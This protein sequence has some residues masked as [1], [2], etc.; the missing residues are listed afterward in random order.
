M[1]FVNSIV[2]CA[3]CE[4]KKTNVLIFSVTSSYDTSH[5]SSKSVVK[6]LCCYKKRP[7][8]ADLAFYTGLDLLILRFPKLM[9]LVQLRFIRHA[10]RINVVSRM[11]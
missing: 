3:C 8:Y 7:H 5:A 10:Q 1:S 11:G 4:T 9:T 6:I 2:C